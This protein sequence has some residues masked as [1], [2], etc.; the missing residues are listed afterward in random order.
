MKNIN[1]NTV[2]RLRVSKKLYESIQQ[3][4]EKKHDKKEV[5]EGDLAEGDMVNMAMQALDT[6]TDPA[7]QKYLLGLG[8]PAAIFATVKKAIDKDKASGAKDIKFGK[9]AQDK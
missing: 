9:I 5:K 7:V 4:L 2:L 8:I 1:D 6:I 3:E